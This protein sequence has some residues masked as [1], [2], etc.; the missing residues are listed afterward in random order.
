[1]V[2]HVRVYARRLTIHIHY[3]QAQPCRNCRYMPRSWPYTELRNGKKRGIDQSENFLSSNPSYI[4]T[5][6]SLYLINK[7]NFNLYHE[8]NRFNFYVNGMICIVEQKWKE[9]EIELT[10]WQNTKLDMISW[11]VHL[12]LIYIPFWYNKEWKVNSKKYWKCFRYFHF[13][14]VEQQFVCITNWLRCNP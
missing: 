11:Y 12:N 9:I 3:T 4:M 6:S 13:L 10:N 14:Q 5:I 8:L 2:I 1:M 7:L